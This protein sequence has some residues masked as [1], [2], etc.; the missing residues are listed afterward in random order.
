MS[1]IK[2]NSFVTDE[3]LMSMLQRKI[4]IGN[5][6]YYCTVNSCYIF[7]TE[8]Y[9]LKAIKMATCIIEKSYEF[10]EFILVEME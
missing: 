9:Y 5:Q 7:Y 4:D 2:S 10:Y 6:A 1:I 8:L 3:L